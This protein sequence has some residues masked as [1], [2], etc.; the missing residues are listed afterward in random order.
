[1]AGRRVLFIGHFGGRNIGDEAML[2]AMA[3]ALAEFS[4]SLSVAARC[5]PNP[6]TVGPVDIVDVRSL[7]MIR[8]LLNIDDLVWIAGTT[9]H[10]KF[11]GRRRAQHFRVILQYVALFFVA[12]LVGVKVW[13]V[14]CGLGP[15]N[16]RMSRVLLRLSLWLVNGAVLR[17]PGSYSEARRSWNGTKLHLGSDAAFLLA[18]SPIAEVVRKRVGIS[19]V[20][21]GTLQVTGIQEFADDL[22]N[23]ISSRL[24]EEK[25]FEVEI[26]MI[27][28]GRYESDKVFSQEIFCKLK[29]VADE[30]V[31]YNE[32]TSNPYQLVFDLSAC[33]YL[34]MA[35]YHAV[36]L[37][38]LAGR[39][40]VV[41]PYHEKVAGICREI[42]VPEEY[43][44]KLGSTEV[45]T[46]LEMLLR[47]ES[48]LL[49]FVIPGAVLNGARVNV[50]ALVGEPDA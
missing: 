18:G 6:D 5:C 16:S 1:M 25:D 28:D 42:G 34:V 13:W 3:K 48:R 44:I 10:D 49:P 8:R 26:F 46:N 45:K 11:S 36:V 20:R 30:R 29:A 27:S 19:L 39:P 40:M 23:I 50:T 47:S 35:R 37:G 4:S 12:R 21:P 33:E 14:S 9:F 41:V 2:A 32:N 38:A 24:V 22:V 15:F 43:I 17:D 31:F 7:E